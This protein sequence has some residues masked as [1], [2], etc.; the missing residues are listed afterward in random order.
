MPASITPQ[1]AARRIAEGAILFDIRET[2][3]RARSYV[4]GS[5][6]APLSK[7]SAGVV[8]DG[9]PA[10]IFHCRSGQRTQANAARLSAIVASDTPVYLLAGGLDGWSAAGLPLRADQR[11]PIELMRQVQIAA[12]LLILLGAALGAFVTSAFYGLSAFV[13]AGLLVAGVTGWC[14]MARVLAAMP[15]NRHGTAAV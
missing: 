7:I 1:D 5:R 14:G 13:G 4:P 11:Q 12:G 2:D 3:E 10:V 9:V 15:W 6:H 8:P